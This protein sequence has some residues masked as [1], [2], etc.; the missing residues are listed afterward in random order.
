MMTILPP[1]HYFDAKLIA[2]QTLCFSEKLAQFAEFSKNEDVREALNNTPNKLIL[3]VIGSPQSGKSTFISKL[4]GWDLPMVAPQNTPNRLF[5]YDASSSLPHND[6]NLTTTFIADESLIHVDIV[7]VRQPEQALPLLESC[8]IILVTLRVSE[9]ES[10]HIWNLLRELPNALRQQTI[11]LLTHP[12]ENEIDSKD[13]ITKELTNKLINLLHVR[14]RAYL[15]NLL[16]ESPIPFEITSISRDITYNG[17]AWGNKLE[18]L[19]LQ[20]RQLLDEQDTQL[21]QLHHIACADSAFIDNLEQELNMLQEKINLDVSILVG[22]YTRC[23][24]QSLEVLGRKTVRQLGLLLGLR[25]SMILHRLDLATHDSYFESVMIEVMRNHER[26]NKHLLTQCEQHWQRF[27]PIIS[28]QLKHNMGDFHAEDLSLKLQTYTARLGIALYDPFCAFGLK[29]HIF[30]TYLLEQA[31]MI[32]VF[33]IMFSICIAGGLFGVLQEHT[34]G[35]TC[36]ALAVLVWL[37]GSIFLCMT[38]RKLAE[39]V[40]E[41]AAPLADK[42]QEHLAVVLPPLMMNSVA[43]YRRMY[44]N[45]KHSLVTGAI[46]ITPLLGEHRSLRQSIAM[47][48]RKDR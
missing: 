21:R 22:D 4:M 37:A 42:V 47:L 7:E 43:D 35:I 46:I 48:C 44:N 26:Y 17:Y 40:T 30:Q 9:I 10:T 29:R 23:I 14:P 1:K 33:I 32:R 19:L 39:A 45:I 41:A 11:I 3:G 25:R 16:E 2:E 38:R 12:T 18:G 13:K 31:W 8:S 28:A 15:C 6:G 27:R 20:T 5:C 34:L 36:L 24:E